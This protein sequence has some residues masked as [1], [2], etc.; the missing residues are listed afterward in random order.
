MQQ[1]HLNILRD[2][3]TIIPQDSNWKPGALATRL[4]LSWKKF[5]SYSYKGKSFSKFSNVLENEKLLHR[6]KVVVLEIQLRK[7]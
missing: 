6:A 4:T 2:H 7:K 1:L 3:N 5:D